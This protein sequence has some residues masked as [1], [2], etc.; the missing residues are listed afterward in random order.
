MNTLKDYIS[1]YL[2]YCEYRK[3]L[4]FK[5]I[6]AYNTTYCK[7]HRSCVPMPYSQYNMY[8]LIYNFFCRFFTFQGN[9]PGVDIIDF[10]S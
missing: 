10:S 2:N 1:E 6:K 7:R 3:Q 5:T 9:L 4:N 8:T